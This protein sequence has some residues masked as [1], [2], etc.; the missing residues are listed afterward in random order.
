[1]IFPRSCHNG[2][3]PPMDQAERHLCSCLVVSHENRASRRLES[4]IMNWLR[5]VTNSKPSE[6]IK[7]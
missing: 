4:A 5:R 7:V 2:Y 1:M 6:S 3:F